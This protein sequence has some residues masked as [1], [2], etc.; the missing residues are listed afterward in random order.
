MTGLFATI[1]ILIAQAYGRGTYN[2]LK[3]Q[4]T[5]TLGPITIPVKL[6]N[7]GSLGMAAGSICAL[8]AAI[9]IYKYTKKR[10]ERNKG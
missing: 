7:V 8:V 4:D 1:P 2:S 5:T 6:P 3:Y 10:E 9:V